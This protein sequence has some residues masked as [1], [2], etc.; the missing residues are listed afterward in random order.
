[1]GLALISTVLGVLENWGQHP[2]KRFHESSIKATSV[3]AWGLEDWVDRFHLLIDIWLSREHWQF[4]NTKNPN[5][6]VR[7]CP[8]EDGQADQSPTWQSYS[9]GRAA[10][11][12]AVWAGGWW[13]CVVG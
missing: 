6:S 3:G 8:G 1:M 10:V 9:L 5:P 12:Q 4:A 2:I 13:G 11:S 7:T